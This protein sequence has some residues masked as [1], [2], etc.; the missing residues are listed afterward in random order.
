[1]YAHLA[2]KQIIYYMKRQKFKTKLELIQELGI[3]KSTFYRMLEKKRIQ[4]TRQMLSPRDENELRVEL[5]FA[6]L[7]GFEF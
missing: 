6:P 5:G 4:T 2:S 7:P 1:I 3:S